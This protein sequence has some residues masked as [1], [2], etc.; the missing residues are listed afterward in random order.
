MTKLF[1]SSGIRGVAN[2]EIT[3]E[4][5][6]RVGSALATIHEGGSIVVGRD[7]RVTG[8][9]L[10]AALIS[11]ITSCGA[12]ARITGVLPTPIVAWLTR[13]LEADA[14]VVI[15]ASHNPPEY[16]GFKVFNAEGMS[17][18][19][20]QQGDIEEILG[21]GDRDYAPWDGMGSTEELDASGLYFD[22]LGDNVNVEKDWKVVCDCNCGAAGVV[23]SECFESLGLHPTLIN[24]NPNGHFPAGSPEPTAE[25]LRRLGAYV[26]TVGSEVGFGF[27]G[28]ADRMMAVDERGIPVSGDMLF[29]AY[30]AYVCEAKRGGVVVTHVG[31]S[32]CVEDLVEAVGGKVVRVRVGDAFIT[33][34]MLKRKAVF[35]GEPIG[36]WVFPEFHMCPD[37]LLSAL[38]LL[39]A[40]ENK[41]MK[42]SEF[43]EEAKRYPISSVKIE[44]KAKTQVMKNVINNYGSVFKGVKDVN[45]IDGIRLQLDEGWVLIRASGTEP[46]IRITAEGR[47]LSNMNNLIDRGI[48]LIKGNED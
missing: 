12:D 46:L 25:N 35:G 4:L 48:E 2:V 33:E 34:E 23:A 36:A 1:G 15:T 29:A 3:S 39:E 16:N 6:Q 11:G 32:M 19:E 22:A 24:A 47:D 26:K 10:E 41:D 21:G 27:D 13:E 18:T 38:K 37:G 45:R 17:I 31:A 30:A 8:P 14:G 42:L 7:V 28:D 5:A 20:K 44:T 43:A 40:L 9:M